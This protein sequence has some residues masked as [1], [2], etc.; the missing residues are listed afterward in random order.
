MSE[1]KVVE[2][3][4]EDDSLEIIFMMLFVLHR[5]NVLND[6]RLWDVSR[7]VM[8]KELPA[9]ATEW[10]M[11]KVKEYGERQRGVGRVV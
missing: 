10:F 1:E 3:R 2:E 9:N 4:K 5:L 6:Q 7:A 11:G 8:K